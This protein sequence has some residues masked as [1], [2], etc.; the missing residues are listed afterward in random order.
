M[1]RDFLS[2]LKA[3]ADA[4]DQVAREN[5]MLRSQLRTAEARI[6]RLEQETRGP[7]KPGTSET[8]RTASD[9]S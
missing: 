5:G 6:A 9:G 8:R 1:T 3:R 7:E 4:A 2:R